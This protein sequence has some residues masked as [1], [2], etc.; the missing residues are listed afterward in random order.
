MFKEIKE[1]KDCFIPTPDNKKTFAQTV[2]VEKTKIMMIGKKK[3]TDIYKNKS[4]GVA[5]KL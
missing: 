5:N 4:E 3:V 1:C 2:R